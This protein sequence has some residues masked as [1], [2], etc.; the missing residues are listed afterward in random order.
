VRLAQASFG[1]GETVSNRSGTV[2]VA[3][4]ICLALTA[5]GGAR[6][7]RPAAHSSATYGPFAAATASAQPAS[8]DAACAD[9][10]RAERALEAS[11]DKDKSNPTALDADFTAFASRLSAD[12]QKETNPAAATAM[13]SLASDYTDL[14][15]SQTGGAELP[16]MSTVE[17]DGRAFD[18]ACGPA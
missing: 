9:A 13:T 6:S 15:Q 4:V 12:A 10:V 18:Q 5:C 2:T 11:Q 8:P 14:V 3:A 7:D 1:Q 17:R 16:G